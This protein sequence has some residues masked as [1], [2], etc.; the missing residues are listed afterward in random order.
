MSI[1]NSNIH[2]KGE[3]P[4]IIKLPN[5][6]IRVVRR[7][8]KFTR[9]DIDNANLGSLMG[10]FGDV[11]TT[12]EQITNQ[13]YTNCKLISVEVDNRF[14]Q[15]A[16]A[17]NPVLV[18]TYETLTD[19]F[20]EVSDPTVTFT[21]N[22]LKEITKIYRAD[23]GTTST[24]VVGVATLATG[25]I[26]ATSKIE[27]N[28]AF[29]ELTEVY[30]E[31][32]ILNVT[33]GRDDNNQ[34]VTVECVELT[35][36]QVSSELSSLIGDHTL[37]TEATRNRDGFETNVYTY[38]IKDLTTLETTSDDLSF[39]RKI[40]L[41]ESN[42]DSGT[43]NSTELT[44]D[45]DKYTLR[46]EEINNT[47]IIKKR[48]R[49][50]ALYDSSSFPANTLFE[51][52]RTYGIALP[53]ARQ[54]VPASTASGKI[55]STEAIQ[56]E[57][58]DSFR[59]LSY[60]I[61]ASDVATHL[62]TQV[63]YEKRN[64]SLFPDELESV[65]IG[66]T[67]GKIFIANYKETPKVGLKAKIT[68]TFHWGAPNNNTTVTALAYSPQ[69]FS[70]FVEID[71]TRNSTTETDS[72]STGSSEGTSRVNSTS[73]SDNSSNST[74]TSTSGNTTTSTVDSEGNSEN[75]TT[76]NS[77]NET[78]SE[79]NSTTESSS[80]STLTSNTTS[81]TTSNNTSDTS[82]NTSTQTSSSSGSSGSS[83]SGSTVSSNSSSNTSTNSTGNS[84]VSSN[85]NGNSN[86]TV[87]SN[88]TSGS[89]S[90]STTDTSGVTRSNR[91]ITSDMKQTIDQNGTDKIE[92]GNSKRDTKSR[93]DVIPDEADPTR[94]T[95]V[96]GI[97]SETTFKKDSTGTNNT[98][99]TSN[100]VNDS[101]GN[102]TTNT[103]QNGES[104][105]N[106]NTNTTSSGNNQVNSNTTSNNSSNS[107]TNSTTN[108][109]NNTNSSSN[110]FSNSTNNS[111]SSGNSSVNSVG[112]STSNTSGDTTNSTTG[113]S[114]STVNSTSTSDGSNE[115][116]SESKGRTKSTSVND[117]SGSST[118]S[119]SSNGTSRTNSTS[120]SNNTS[121]ST[122]H[123]DTT[124]ASTTKQ[125]I[126]V[127]LKSCLRNA[128][129]VE[130]L[131]IPATTPT[132]IPRAQYIEIERSSSHWKYNIWVEQSVE[133]YLP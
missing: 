42:F 48:S 34:I 114:K 106:V 23:S 101:S 97:E 61:L 20:V 62:G 54:I 73:V 90:N 122:S 112:S 123:T 77:Q 11:D 74:T 31:S 79:N 40:E 103:S 47:G 56:V 4:E 18:K 15:Q 125:L 7:F 115:S 51:I 28:T 99:G 12:N 96:E 108:I 76:T 27:D 37:A 1:G 113:T 5:N 82:S 102:V 86:S 120:T 60:K 105:S 25:E 110:N 2:Q 36:T 83:S 133:V 124:S 118:S 89:S 64:V 46:K 30:R 111:N 33:V 85:S 104:N 57:P 67:E 68:R 98:T 44:L 127:N 38:K 109:N 92:S 50:F 70:G 6:R 132:G 53:V 100:T 78:T 94:H 21:E 26:L 121:N 3:I 95:I 128:T 63:W 93:I 131:T 41:S 119:S 59:S 39:V 19:S 65:S 66:G 87:N 126:P 49:I 130:G 32:G 80:E 14:N 45:S 29:A 13:G 69:P 35:S 16:N 107:S 22:N 24:N 81:E 91:T 17:D 72:T 129:T 88:S 55:D 84:T 43:I 10:D 116:T 75:K 9:E 8:H 71:V 58:V 52:D 117:T